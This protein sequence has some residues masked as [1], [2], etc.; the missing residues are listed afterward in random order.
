ME[1]NYLNNTAYTIILCLLSHINTD[2]IRHI[3]DFLKDDYKKL[4]F[5]S[6]RKQEL[7]PVSDNNGNSI[8]TFRIGN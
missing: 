7:F 5:Q 6:I 2:N 1:K 3:W 8:G 4:Y